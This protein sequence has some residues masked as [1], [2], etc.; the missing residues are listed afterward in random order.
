MIAQ[1]HTGRKGSSL[2]P[3]SSPTP[4]LS[5]LHLDH[6]VFALSEKGFSAPCSSLLPA[7]SLV[8]VG[9]RKTFPVKKVDPWHFIAV[10]MV[11][12]P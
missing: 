7:C 8:G 6:L 4:V 9:V 2:N 12:K 11:E 1:G 3:N 5:A 10:F